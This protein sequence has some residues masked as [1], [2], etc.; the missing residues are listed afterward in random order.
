MEL[1]KVVVFVIYVVMEESITVL[2]YINGSIVY[3]S[4]S[5]EY[6][7]HPHTA[8]KIKTKIKFGELEDKLSRVFRVDRSE[9]RLTIIYRYPQV[10]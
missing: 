8:I 6:H 9:N 5:I 7:H 4:N 10:V 1:A 3:R 2:C